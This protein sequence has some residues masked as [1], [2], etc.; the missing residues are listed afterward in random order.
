MDQMNRTAQDVFA[1]FRAMSAEELVAY[2]A[3]NVPGMGGIL[4]DAA[5]RMGETDFLT[6]CIFTPTGAELVWQWIRWAVLCGIPDASFHSF[7][8]SRRAAL[9][10]NRRGKPTPD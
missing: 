1:S 3:G 4:R 8:M 6:F 7:A 2:M 10:T 5:E 9:V